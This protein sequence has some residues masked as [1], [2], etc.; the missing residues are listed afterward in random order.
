MNQCTIRTKLKITG[1]DQTEENI[2]WSVW[3]KF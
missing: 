2:Q 3:L 1:I